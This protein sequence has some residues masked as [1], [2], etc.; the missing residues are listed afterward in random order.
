MKIS[1]T[2]KNKHN[3]NDVTVSTEG[4]NKKINI[5][6]KSAG[7]GSLVNGGELL[8][9]SLATCF[10]NDIY[11]EAAKRNINID[12]VEVTVS[13]EFGAEGE[14]ATYI[15]YE[16]KLQAQNCLERELKELIEYT[17]KVAEIHNTLRK[18][19]EIKLNKAV[20]E[21]STNK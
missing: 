7:F 15:N 17:D 21:I 8:F 11:R 14:A 13:G 6:G 20:T 19:I 2:V 5:P 1:A 3:E 9:L 18:G 16:T 10:C 4:N 12:L